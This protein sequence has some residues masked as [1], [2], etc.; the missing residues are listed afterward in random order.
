[1]VATGEATLTPTVHS[2]HTFQLSTNG[3]ISWSQLCTQNTEEQRQSFP[4]SD[5]FESFVFPTNLVRKRHFIMT[6]VNSC[7]MAIKAQEAAVATEAVTLTPTLCTQNTEEQRQSF[8]HSGKRHFI[9]TKVNSCAM[10]IKAQEEAVATEAVTLIPTV[11]NALTFQ[12]S[13]NCTI[14]WIFP[15][16]LR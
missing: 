5:E 3:T 4:H 15:N 7:A 2:A 14:S 11:H 8:P 1:M 10:A 13:T 9:M 16:Q 12:L 6:K